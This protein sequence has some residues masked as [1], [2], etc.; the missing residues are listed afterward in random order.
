[1]KRTKWKSQNSIKFHNSTGH[2]CSTHTQTDIAPR[3][4]E[5]AIL[6]FQGS[7]KAYIILSPQTLLSEINVL[8]LCEGRMQYERCNERIT[9]SYL[10][11]QSL[12]TTAGEREGKQASK[13]TVNGH[14]AYLKGR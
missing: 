9:M 6:M 2:F 3:G 10:D 13:Q 4:F 7:R 14:A 12:R 8:K 5:L 1:M 11:K